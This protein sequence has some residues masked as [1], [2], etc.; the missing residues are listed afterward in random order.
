[1]PE[2]TRAQLKLNI[3]K[4]CNSIWSSHI[5][6]K[7]HCTVFYDQRLLLILLL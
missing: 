5:G 3:K 6:S 1:M 2:I 7:S 4:L